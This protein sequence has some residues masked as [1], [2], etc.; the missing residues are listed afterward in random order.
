[1]QKQHNE[2]NELRADLLSVCG[3]NPFPGTNSASRVQMFSNHLGQKLVT[4]GMSERYIQTGMEKEF[5]KYTLNIKM[6]VDGRVI[7]IIDRYRPTIGI[8][9]IKENP[10]VVVIYEDENT[11]EIGIINLVKHCSFHQYLGFEYKASAGINMLTPNQF[12]P[13][14]TVF[15][16]SPG[17][18]PDGG[19][20]YG[21]NVNMAFMTHPSSSEDGIMI[22]RDVLHKFKFKT[23][24]TRIIEYGSKRFP[25]NMYGTPEDYKPF[26][27]IGDTVRADGL[28][29]ALRTHDKTLVVAE[30]SI[31]DLMEPNEIFD[32]MVF[33]NGGG[34]K[35]VDITIQHDT[36]YNSTTPFGMEKQMEKYDKAR[37]VFYSEILAEYRRLVAS[38]GATLSV[39]YEFG[40][41]IV[42]A[43]S[44]VGDN[45]SQRVAKLYRKAP[46]DDY[47]IE[48][49]I[50]YEIT[51]TDGF[52]LTGCHGD[53][54]VICKVAEPEEMPVDQ[55][56]N[57]ADAVMDPGATISRMNIGRLYE[58]Y[59][60]AASRDVKK[61]IYKF[62]GVEKADKHY[63]AKVS[64]LF[65]NDRAE[66]IKLYEYLIGYYKIV[67]PVMYDCFSALTAEKKLEHLLSLTRDVV[68]LFIPTDND[69][70]LIDMVLEIEKNYKPTY[71]PVTYMGNSGKYVTTENNVMIGSVYLML[72]EKIADVWS[73]IS[74]GKL[75]HFGI[76]SQLTK[77]DKYSQPTR[78][79]AVKALGE[80]EVKIVVG[81]TEPVVSAELMDRNNNPD[82]HKRMVKEIMQNASPTN[83]PVLNDRIVHPYGG[84]KTTGLVKHIA[85]CAGWKYKYTSKKNLP[86]YDFQSL[87]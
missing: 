84:C 4:A 76:L 13:K 9:S 70:E 14:D 72:L 2:H 81:Y 17:V 44:I 10:H 82:T 64:S 25:L 63:F 87:V 83:I 73:S 32:K 37:R 53:K 52:K 43:Y 24:E 86:V 75:Q 41:L 34:G 80:A 12:I 62:L 61:K 21:V 6:P 69:P 11:K 28:L 51:P 77:S 49:T 33:A 31:Y 66:F 3:L 29:G 60:N 18:T 19:Y 79:N 22:C 85:M 68:E 30:Q 65:D 20:A 39:S 58:Q 15:Y 38:Q 47:R 42:E 56:G 23:Y 45:D 74:S 48:F 46:L 26:P 40:R 54:G 1:M 36:N 27:D 35:V 57:R 7:K 16:D 5:G 55:D 50:E 59:L 8:D 71:G 78:N 67:S